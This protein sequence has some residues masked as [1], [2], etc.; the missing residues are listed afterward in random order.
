MYKSILLLIAS[1]EAVTLRNPMQDMMSNYVQVIEGPED[2]S[3]LQFPKDFRP[4]KP[5]PILDADGDGVEDNMDW[6]N[7]AHEL[8]KFYLPHVYGAP[9]EHIYNTRHGELPGFRSKAFYDGQ[10]EPADSYT[11]VKKDWN[12]L[13]D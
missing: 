10:S 11:I 1:S 2:L 13:G 3:N 5:Q 12:R 8:D 4:F 9:V 7:M 6:A